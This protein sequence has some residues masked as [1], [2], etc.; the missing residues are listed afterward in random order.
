MKLSDAQWDMIRE[1]FPEESIPDGRAGRKPIATRAV[2]EAVLWILNT[3]AQWHM[4]PQCYPN[5]KTVHRRFQQWCRS[6]VL[7]NILTDL[8]NTLREQ[9]DID[10]RES[11]I[12]AMFCAAKGGKGV[13]IMGI[14]DRN[15]LPIAVTT[16][17]ANHH[18]VT[19]V[20][21]TFDFYMIEAKPEKLIGDKAYDSDPLDEE[22]AKEGIEMI[23]PHREN[24]LEKNKTQDGRKLRPYCR[25]WL[26]ER[27]FAWLGWQRRLL[28]R[29][30]YHAENFLG[31][32]R[33]ASIKILL[34]R[35]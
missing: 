22:L 21:L 13:K 9:G 17:A 1:H 20:Q 35:F 6:N 14:V 28:T 2:L 25:R 24:R 15:G 34:N 12:D 19:L 16:H 7:R 30:E 31:F 27:F 18:E 4:L 11:F 29:W 10:E 23:A 3:G 8:A 5:Y 33:L 32:V 26:V